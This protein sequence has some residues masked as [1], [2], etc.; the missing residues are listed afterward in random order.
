MLITGSSEGKDIG[1][2]DSGQSLNFDG[3]LDEVNR[4]PIVVARGLLEL[5]DKFLL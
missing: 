5:I 1:L 2:T 3:S 4:L